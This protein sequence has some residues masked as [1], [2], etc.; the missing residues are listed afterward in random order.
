[1]IRAA[2]F[3]PST[4]YDLTEDGQET[5][6]ARRLSGINPVNW[7]GQSPN[8]IRS[9]I[10][11]TFVP[12]TL[13]M[14]GEEELAHDYRAWAEQ[15]PVPPTIVAATGG[16]LKFSELTQDGLQ[17]RFL[18]VCD[19]IPETVDRDSV[20]S[21]KNAIQNWKPQKTRKLGYQVRN[22]N[23][24]RANLTVLAAAGF[25]DMVHGPFKDINVGIQPYVDQIVRTTQ[26]ILEERERVGETELQRI[27][28]PT[29]D[30]TLF[31]PS[32]YPGFWAMPA[33]SK[34]ERDEKKRFLLARKALQR[35]SGYSLE[36][37]VRTH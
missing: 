29:L 32:I 18:Q 24:V 33:P 12:F 3:M 4:I 26:S 19:S 1:M 6:L 28:R 13:V 21:A 9:M 14:L 37:R 5:L 27:F 2:T 10:Q 30:L 23:S 16:N 17:A 8:A 36:L 7:Y 34:M 31:A 15:S 20:E 35:Q 25:E 11:P 22:H